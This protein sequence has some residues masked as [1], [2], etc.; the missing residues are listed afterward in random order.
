L[1]SSISLAIVLLRRVPT[2]PSG[3]NG[4][5]E[6]SSTISKCHGGWGT[7]FFLICRHRV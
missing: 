6:T 7:S 4:V 1:R 2:F 3:N 5:R